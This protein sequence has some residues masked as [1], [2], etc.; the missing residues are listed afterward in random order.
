MFGR[1]D[2]TGTW[3]MVRR[4]WSRISDSRGCFA[5]RRRPNSLPGD[6][7]GRA[8]RRAFSRFTV[9]S[10]VFRTKAS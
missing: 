6:S 5:L 2:A 8:R 4:L 9:G 3:P 10:V 7:P 1:S